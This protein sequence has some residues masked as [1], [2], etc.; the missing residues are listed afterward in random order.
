[1]V[2]KRKSLTTKLRALKQNSRVLN[3][4]EIIE[5]YISGKRPF[6]EF[7]SSKSIRSSKSGVIS[8]S[9]Q[10]QSNISSPSSVSRKRVKAELLLKQ[11]YERFERKSKLLEKQNSLE[12]ELER[13]KIIEAENQ[14]KLLELKDACNLDK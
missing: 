10:S 4:N 14:L 6:T 13:E 12:L 2:S 8:N 5:K 11:S 1:M 3:T 9:S 7:L